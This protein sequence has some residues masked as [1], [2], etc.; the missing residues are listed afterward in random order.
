MRAFILTVALVL[1]LTGLTGPGESGRE[2]YVVS[3]DWHTGIVI[4][5]SL[6][7]EQLPE[8]K[9]RFGNM[10]YMEFGWGDKAFYQAGEVTAALTLSALFWPTDS[11]IHAVALPYEPEKYFSGSQVEKLCVPTPQYR[12]LVRFIVDNFQRDAADSIVDLGAGLYGNSRFYNAVGDYHALYNCNSWIAAGLQRMGMDIVPAATL[13]ADSV[14]GHVRR[15]NKSRE[16]I[17]YGRA[18][19]EIGI[20]RDCP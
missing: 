1:P 5:A 14:M 4:P 17:P 13:T 20:I 18:P 12:A 3:H 7:Q 6:I 15:Y 11:V 2:V 19:V 9:K 10:P 16:R 8:L